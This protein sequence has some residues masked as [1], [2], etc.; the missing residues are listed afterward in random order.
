MEHDL[1]TQEHRFRNSH[2]R[3]MKF[4]H[5]HYAATLRCNITMQHFNATLHVYITTD[6]KKRRRGGTIRHKNLHPKIRSDLNSR[7]G[8]STLTPARPFLN[9][10]RSTHV[11]RQHGN[12]AQQ[13]YNRCENKVGSRPHGGRLLQSRPVQTMIKPERKTLTEH[14]T[15]EFRADIHTT[16][17]A[18]PHFKQT[19]CVS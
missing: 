9:H 11:P 15:P 8:S 3:N 17:S 13:H 6:V 16:R 4:R 14:P 2:T 10:S 12:L 18:K 7:R 5:T 19:Q 1:R